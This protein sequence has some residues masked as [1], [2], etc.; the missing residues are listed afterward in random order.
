MGTVNVS[1]HNCHVHICQV[2]DVADI[3]SSMAGVMYLPEVRLLRGSPAL[4]L[5]IEKF[6]GLHRDRRV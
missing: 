3:S 2:I 5:E 4:R 6:E 1:F